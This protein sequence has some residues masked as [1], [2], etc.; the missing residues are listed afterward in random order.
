M[1]SA[2]AFCQIL[3]Y[4]RPTTII[5]Y[6]TRHLTTCIV[7]YRKEPDVWNSDGSVGIV[8]VLPD[9]RPRIPG[10][11]PGRSE[12]FYFLQNVT[13]TQEPHPAIYGIPEA[14]CPG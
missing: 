2:L 9:G 3:S 1:N 7:Y 13:P 8:T 12:D 14:F 4:P 6:F 10:S 5:P 11:I